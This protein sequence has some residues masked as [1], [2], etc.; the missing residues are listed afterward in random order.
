MDQAVIMSQ[1]LLNFLLL[2]VSGGCGWFLRELWGAHK[3]LRRELS[4]LKESLPN[5]YAAKG[6]IDQGF[7]RLFDK[8]DEMRD[9]FDKRMD[10]HE[11]RYHKATPI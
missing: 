1:T 11:D 6:V 9:H 5:T 4:Q 8:L 10:A 2:T 7:L 3:E